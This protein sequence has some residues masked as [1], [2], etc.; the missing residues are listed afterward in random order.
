MMRINPC[1]G[2]VDD[3][4]LVP[5]DDYNALVMAQVQLN[6]IRVI[7]AAD[8]RTYTHLDERTENAVEALLGI[9]RKEKAD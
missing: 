2:D 5:R 7:I 9:E 8:P 6:D 3:M 4:V 1:S